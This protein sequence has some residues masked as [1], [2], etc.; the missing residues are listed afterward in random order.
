MD[1]KGVIPLDSTS[2]ALDAVADTKKPCSFGIY[3]QDGKRTFF[4]CAESEEQKRAWMLAIQAQINELAF[5]NGEEINKF[6]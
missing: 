3:S 1:P 2:V 5:S 6:K 4:L